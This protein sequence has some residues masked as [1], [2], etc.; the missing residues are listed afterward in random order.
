[1][2]R[3][4]HHRRQTAHHAGWPSEAFK[5]TQRQF[6]HA[7]P[8]NHRYRRVFSTHSSNANQYNLTS[9]KATFCQVEKIISS[10]FRDLSIYLVMALE[11]ILGIVEHFW[12]FPF[13]I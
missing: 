8:R 13:S 5:E 7:K 11:V 4:R 9:P 2:E 6:L 10:K 1:M 12:A 3:A